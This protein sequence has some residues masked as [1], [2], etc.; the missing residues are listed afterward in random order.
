MLTS[1]Q[2]NLALNVGEMSAENQRQYFEMLK[3]VLTEEEIKAF[4]I[5]V[6]YFRMKNNPDREKAMKNALAIQLYEEFNRQ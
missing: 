6:A 4:Q 3:E 2:V 1:E 5:V